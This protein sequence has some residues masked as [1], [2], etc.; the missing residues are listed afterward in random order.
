[1]DFGHACHHL[2]LYR[3]NISKKYS[4]DNDDA[5]KII[6]YMDININLAAV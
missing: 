4:H 6:Y 1:M 3:L 2:Y 5:D